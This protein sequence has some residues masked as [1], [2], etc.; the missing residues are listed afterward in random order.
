MRK[1]CQLF[2]LGE[3]TLQER[4]DVQMDEYVKKENE[5]MFLSDR[6]VSE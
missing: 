5:S 3:H 2:C 1:I 6:V 4:L